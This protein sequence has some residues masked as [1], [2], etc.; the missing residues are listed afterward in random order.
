MCGD[1]ILLEPHGGAPRMLSRIKLESGA[2]RNEAWLRDLIRDHPEL[3]PVR[4]MDPSYKQ[5]AALCTELRTPAGPID[6]GFD[7]SHERDHRG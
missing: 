1:F 7:R 5:I 3:L 6:A 2:S 4:Q